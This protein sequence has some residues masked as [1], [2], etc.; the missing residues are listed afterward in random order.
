VKAIYLRA[1]LY[2]AS[3]ALLS[4]CGKTADN[5]LK[6][7]FQPKESLVIEKSVYSCFQSVVLRGGFLDRNGNLVPPEVQGPLVQFNRLKMEWTRNNKLYIH[8]LQ[9]RFRGAGISGGESVCDLSTELMWLFEKEG[10]TGDR[11]NDPALYDAG[12]FFKKGEI[13]SN[14]L[15]RIACPIALADM[16][17]PEISA[18]GEVT[19][20]GTEV[21]DE[22]TDEEKVFRVRTRVNVI[23]RP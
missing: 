8:S 11:V 7:S 12:T 10:P 23:V 5:T 4:S 19:V 2:I 14:P 13:I 17:V 22:G 9:I 15:C 21:T 6:V 16:N 3:F 20:K 1:T 18:V